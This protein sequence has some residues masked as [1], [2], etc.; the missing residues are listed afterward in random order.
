LSNAYKYSPAGSPIEVRAEREGHDVVTTVSDCGQGVAAADRERIFEKFT[1]LGDHLTRPQQGIGLGLF[2]AR[3]T[4]EQLGGA[5]W[6]DERPG[7]GAR[8]SFRLPIGPVPAPTK[9]PTR[10][11]KKALTAS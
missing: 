5:I 11:R 7:G 6:C 8:F 2:I 9:A 3:R 10:R 1:R 4:I